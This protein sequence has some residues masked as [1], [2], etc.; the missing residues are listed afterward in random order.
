MPP[1]SLID[2]DW[3][4]VVKQERFRV[5]AF[6]GIRIAYVSVVAMKCFK[7]HAPILYAEG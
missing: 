6:V 5:G 2:A 3:V 7:A 1:I 4:G